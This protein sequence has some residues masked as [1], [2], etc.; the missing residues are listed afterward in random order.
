VAFDELNDTQLNRLSMAY[1]S[2][3]PDNTGNSNLRP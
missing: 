1:M 3:G 2:V